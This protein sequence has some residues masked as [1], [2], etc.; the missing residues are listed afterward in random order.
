[1][2]V[3]KLVQELHALSRGEKLRIVQLLVNDLKEEED[4]L[5]LTQSQYE[6]WSPSDAGEAAR[7][8]LT[9]LE[10]AKQNDDL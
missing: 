1:M 3:D 10:E 8:L 9:M 2:R 4:N 6:V 7:V 5:T